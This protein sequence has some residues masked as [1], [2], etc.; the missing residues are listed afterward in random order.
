MK[1][2]EKDKAM[3]AELRS[4]GEVTFKAKVH[5]LACRIVVLAGEV[6]ESFYP[7]PT[8]VV[9]GHRAYNFGAR[10]DE[11]EERERRLAMETYD[12]N[13]VADLKLELMDWRMSMEVDTG[14][15][16]VYPV[17][18]N[19]Q[20]DDTDRPGKKCATIHQIAFPVW[21]KIRKRMTPEEEH[22]FILLRFSAHV[23]EDLC[24]YR[25]GVE[26]ITGLGLDLKDPKF[27]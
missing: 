7:K 9:P 10:E 4:M 20:N 18:L 13:R 1:I 27:W 14:F 6:K 22:L 17:T 16:S 25:Y 12:K 15:D 21:G 5:E 11:F 8:P 19:Q 23:W 24:H 3:L 26:T 2:D